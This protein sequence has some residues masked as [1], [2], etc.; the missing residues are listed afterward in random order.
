MKKTLLQPGF[1]NRVVHRLSAVADASRIRLLLRL[2]E[3]EANVATLSKELGVRQA[4]VSKH[5]GV[6]RRV[7]LVVARRSGTKAIYAIRDDAVF[8]M[9]AIVCDGA[10]RHA[11]LEGKESGEESEE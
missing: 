2:R 8:K 10:R 1:L 11:R 9:R 5:L 6:L 7:G 3:G 4:L